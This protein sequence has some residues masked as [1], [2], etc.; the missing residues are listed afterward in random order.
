MQKSITEDVVTSYKKIKIFFDSE[1]LP[2]TRT[3]LG[4]SHFPDGLAFYQDR[5]KHYTTTTLSYEQIYQLGLKSSQN[6]GGNDGGVE[7]SEI[8]G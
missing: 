1:Y 2:K 3:T 5:V 6:P 8:Q 4:A 7:G